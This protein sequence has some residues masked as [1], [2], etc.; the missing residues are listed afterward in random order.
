MEMRCILLRYELNTECYLASFE[1]LVFIYCSE[2]FACT[3]GIG[4]YHGSDG[5]S[6]VAYSARS[7]HF[8]RTLVRVGFVVDRVGCGQ[9]CLTDV[10]FLPAK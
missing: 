7:P 3:T 9:V 8:C 6:P 10:G 5:L 1:A 4:L 2:G